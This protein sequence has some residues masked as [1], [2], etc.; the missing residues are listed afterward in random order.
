MAFTQDIKGKILESPAEQGYEDEGKIE[1]VWGVWD[2]TA[3]TTGNLNLFCDKVLS[4]S[5]MENTSSPGAVQ[6]ELDQPA[7]GQVRLTF[8]SGHGG[9]FEA[10]ILNRSF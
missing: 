8:T 10:L 9:T 3:V 7:A 1:R 6:V 4:C 5:V 2:G